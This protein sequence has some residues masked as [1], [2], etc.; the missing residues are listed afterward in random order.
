MKDRDLDEFG[1]IFQRAIIPTIEVS[2]IEIRD[3]VVLFDFSDRAPSCMRAARELAQRFDCRVSCRFLL[4]DADAQWEQ[5]ARGLLE[6]ARVSQG[7]I[8]RGDPAAHI[9]K[10]TT[11]DKPSLIIAPAP[12][13][14]HETSAETVVEGEFVDSLLV[15]TAIPTLLVRE[16]FQGSPFGCIL[17]KIPGG[18]HDLIEQFSFA[19]ALCEPGGTIRLLHV[20]DEGRLK[21]LAEV[22]EVAPEI[23]T[24]RGSADL[25]SAIQA[26]MSHLL[27]GAVR[28]A[29]DAAFSVET[30]IRVGDPF[31]IVPE[32]A[33]GCSLLIVGSHGSHEEF[34]DSRAYGLMQRVPHI[35]VLAL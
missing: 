16:P 12:L 35:P 32:E 5:D 33:A 1:S 31:V 28:T 30:S 34:L 25:L 6:E 14:A 4:R 15:A 20:V 2:A 17:A 27:Q 10:I 19:F 8:I 9:V 18:R 3:V 21:L 11:E 24:E 26:R 13:R 7:E 29:K 22:L 23:E